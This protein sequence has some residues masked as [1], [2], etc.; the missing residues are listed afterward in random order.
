MRCP[1]ALLLLSL[2]C[3]GV[4]VDASGAASEI[5]AADAG[6]PPA[7]GASEPPAGELDR[8][9]A[10][11]RFP[12]TTELVRYIVA[13]GCAAERN[14]CH[15]SEDFPDL[16]TE[17][18][19]WNLV[20]LRCNAG[21]GDR[22]EV[23]DFCEPEGDLLRIESGPDALFVARIGHIAGVVGAD[24]ALDHYEISLDA[25][26]PSTAAAVRF[27]ILRDGTAIP[28]LGGGTSLET[29]AGLPVVRV[30]TTEEIPDPSAVLQG[31]EN[32]NGVFGS[33]TGVLVHAGSPRDSYLIRRL[34]GESTDRVRMPLGANADTETEVN[35][36]LTREEMYVV[37]SWVS[38]MQPGDGPYSPIRYDCEANAANDGSW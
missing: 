32:G 30:H 19:L 6:P 25:P 15:N 17:G 21:L 9:R 33:G 20:G 23:E 36:P 31:D 18:N 14:E 10:Q 29:A 16:S 1:S 12:T 13:P 11:A 5:G 34:F 8:E 27:A 7:D 26:P 2:G 37:M 3:N 24:G 38:C 22:G 28:G 4:V 35:P